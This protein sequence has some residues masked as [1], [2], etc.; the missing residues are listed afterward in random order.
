MTSNAGESM[1]PQD[2]PYYSLVASV[3]NKSSIWRNILTVTSL[4]AAWHIADGTL[5]TLTIDAQPAIVHSV[6][7]IMTTDQPTPME[8]GLR[9]LGELGGVLLVV[10]SGSYVLQA[11]RRRRQEP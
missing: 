6:S 11:Y 4:S 9:A 8:E 3:L 7:E 5:D 2:T 1:P 10:E